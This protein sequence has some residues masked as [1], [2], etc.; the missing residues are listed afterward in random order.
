MS[1][2]SIVTHKKCQASFHWLVL[3]SPGAERLL[4]WP[5]CRQV[6]FP[7][8]GMR[9]SRYV[10]IY[11]GKRP[12]IYIHTYVRTYVHT[13]IHI[14]TY[15]Y[16]YIHIHTYTYIYIH[17]HTYTYIYIHI[18]TYTYIYIHIHTYTYIYIHIHTYTYIYIHIHTLHYITLH[19]I[20]LHYITLHYI[21]Y[22]HDIYIYMYN[23][24]VMDLYEPHV[25][26][27]IFR[28]RAWVCGY[29]VR[30]VLPQISLSQKDG[31]HLLARSG[32]GSRSH[33]CTWRWL[34]GLREWP[35]GDWWL[36]GS[37]D[38]PTGRDG[39][40]VVS[41]CLVFR[42][43]GV[44]VR[45]RLSRSHQSSIYE[46]RFRHDETTESGWGGRPYSTHRAHPLICHDIF[47]I[48]Y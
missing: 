19:Y 1:I 14:H 27:G 17:I 40:F 3:T 9:W 5:Q 28:F 26:S 15:T 35:L 23:I 37:Q 44:L 11:P 43:I 41:S 6:W 46:L 38:E 13:Y 31:S 34:R 47:M 2:S 48:I 20:T 7:S 42:T 18:H 4:S 39:F 10:Q 8:V 29:A 32:F 22:I 12:Y 16:I 30:I 24:H 25:W 45:Q 21:T 36:H 33:R